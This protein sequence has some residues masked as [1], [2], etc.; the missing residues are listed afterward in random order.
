[1]RAS[2]ITASPTGICQPSRAGSTSICATSA[3]RPISRPRL[4]VHGVKLT[5]KPRIRSL[6]AIKASAAGEA[7]PPLMPT[8]QGWSANS[9]CPHTE[10]ANSAPLASA[11]AIRAASAA[12]M[13]APRPAR[14]SGRWA[15]TKASAK[16][17][18]AAGSG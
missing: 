7:K 16:A 1:M 10:V 11:N 18:T 4:V 5:P 13:T 6:S 15:A 14:I 17:A 12:A 2:P 9:P 3:C 8:D